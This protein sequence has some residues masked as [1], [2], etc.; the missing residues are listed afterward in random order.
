[1]FRLY[2]ENSELQLCRLSLTTL[3][4]K[5]AQGFWA[6]MLLTWPKIS[7]NS[8]LQLWLSFLVMKYSGLGVISSSYV[9]LVADLGGNWG[10]LPFLAELT[11]VWRPFLEI[12]CPL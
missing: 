4:R 9:T 5:G 7:P 2:S 6:L 1:M 10:Q 8:T 11:Q 12:L 3:E